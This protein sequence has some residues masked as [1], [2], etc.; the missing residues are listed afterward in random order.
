[1][2]NLTL[3]DVLK[4]QKLKPPKKV[5]PVTQE[6]IHAVLPHLLPEVA[7]MVQLQLVCP[8]RPDEI[9][10]MRPMDI[11]TSQVV[12]KYTI[13]SRYYGGLGHKTDW[14]DGEDKVIYLG[15]NAQA[16]LTPLL[17]ACPAK[18]AFL[19]SPKRA[20][21]AQHDRR[22]KRPAKQVEWERVLNDRYNDASYRKAVTR[23]CKVVGIPQWTPNRLRHTGATLIR[24]ELGVQ[25]AQVALGHKNLSTTQIYAE[26]SERLQREVASKMG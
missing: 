4:N 10:I 24:Q 8:L 20:V 7:A 3:Q 6:H 19:F 15:P 1:M 26:Q 23:A 25:A 16:I 5:K 14:I 22:R 11:D 13:G 2:E 21:M 18:D 9:T 17:A 12:W